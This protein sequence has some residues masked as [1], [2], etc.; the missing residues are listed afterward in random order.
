MDA[1]ESYLL[2]GKED[3]FDPELG[4]E[5]NSLA[6]GVGFRI[7]GIDKGDMAFQIRGI[8]DFNGDGFGD[9][10]VGATGAEPNGTLSG[11]SYILFGSDQSVESRFSSGPTPL[12]LPGVPLSS[13]VEGD[14]SE[15]FAINGINPNDAAIV[16]VNPRDR[17][18][19]INGAG[20]L[21]GDGYDDVVVSS[22]GA[23]V[24]GDN[25]GQ[26]YVV[27]GTA[28]KFAESL[29]LSSLNGSNGFVLNG[30][31]PQ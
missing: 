4:L 9:V 2:F 1:G 8:G 12:P 13:L 19:I 18:I 22:P 20:D 10:A 14:G 6:G 15:G 3:G 26:S 29:E 28:E 11:Q 7:E 23:D 30:I 27:F 25:S 31:N 17:A 16:N 24:N 5:L 21:N